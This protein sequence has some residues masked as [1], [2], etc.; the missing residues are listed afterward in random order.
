MN[1]KVFVSGASR[2]IGRAIAEAFAEK[3]D[4]L[5]ITCINNIEEMNSFAGDISTRYGVRCSAYRCDM[6][7]FDEVKE[8]FDEIG[9]VDILIN[10]AVWHG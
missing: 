3:G 10:N 4:E 9:D 6:S 5:F 8:L 2:G 1:R 7:D